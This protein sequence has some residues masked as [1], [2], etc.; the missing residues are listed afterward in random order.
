MGNS[1]PLRAWYDADNDVVRTE[2]TGSI[3]PEELHQ[4]T[5]AAAD[6]ALRHG[7]PRFLSD[8]SDATVTFSMLDLYRDVEM[9]DDQGVPKGLAKIA[10]VPTGG[11]VDGELVRFY[12]SLASLQGWMCRG[13]P[14]TEEALAWLRE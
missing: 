3:S 5:S 2:M 1:V 9:H 10:V 6:L 11:N 13:F 8:Y 12:Q 14:S 7:C 4:E